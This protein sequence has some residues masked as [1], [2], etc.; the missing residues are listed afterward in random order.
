M[1]TVCSSCRQNTIVHDW[2][3]QITSFGDFVHEYRRR[4]TNCDYCTGY[5]PL[6][7]IFL[8]LQPLNNPP[9]EGA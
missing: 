8:S 5:V 4:C 9:A 3:H 7:T 2:L 1:N 6:G